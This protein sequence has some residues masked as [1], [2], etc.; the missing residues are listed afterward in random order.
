MSN[1]FL[2]SAYRKNSAELATVLPDVDVAC[3]TI[4]IATE[5]K[6]MKLQ[7]SKV[8]SSD[9]HATT[10]Q[11]ALPLFHLYTDLKSWLCDAFYSQRRRQTNGKKK[12]AANA[13]LG[14]TVPIRV[15]VF[16]CSFVG[17]FIMSSSID[18]GEKSKHDKDLDQDL[19]SVPLCNVMEL[20]KNKSPFFI[21][22]QLAHFVQMFC[23]VLGFL[24]YPMSC[25]GPY[26]S[27]PRK[28]APDENS[29]IL[30]ACTQNL[31]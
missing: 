22:K 13:S 28:L 12:L 2:L 16:V 5:V 25:L 6:G 7:T 15:H 9:K 8:A 27:V 10:G 24:S 30:T 26:C 20:F 14:I 17:A 31:T 21:S 11:M 1:T 18:R 23:F 3:F 19:K 29:I 4:T